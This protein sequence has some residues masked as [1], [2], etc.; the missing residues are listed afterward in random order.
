M[1][2]GMF[3]TQGTTASGTGMIAC[4]VAVTGAPLPH[5]VLQWPAGW[6]FNFHK[7]HLLPYPHA[8]AGRQL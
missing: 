4:H 3:P 5:R 1:L 7:P 6:L 2:T 8:G